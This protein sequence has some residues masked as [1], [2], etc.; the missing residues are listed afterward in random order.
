MPRCARIKSYDSVYHIMCKANAKGALFTDKA[1]KER[2]LNLIRKYQK[3]HLFKVYA[4]CLMTTHIHM[5]IDCNGSD[6]SKIMHGINQSYAQ[7]FNIRHDSNG[8]VFQDRFKS[9]IVDDDNYLVNLSAYIHNNPTDIK[10]YKNCPEKFYFSSLG[11][12][13]G[14][15]ND[16]HEILDVDFIMERFGSDV[17]SAR[18]KYYKMVLAAKDPDLV[19]E[20]EFTDEKTEYRSGRKILVRDINPEKLINFV[21][22]YTG[23]DVKLFRAKHRQDATKCRALCAFL[24]RCYC[25]FS[26]LQIC[27]VLGGLT[28]SRIASLVNIGLKVI[29]EEDQYKDIAVNFL[30]GYKVA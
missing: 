11:V 19:K 9:K 25:D 3:K 23:V 1:D 26:Y 6:I 8:H 13:L 28:L 20:V 21:M 7:Y 12:Y 14:L 2:Y 18:S 27:E 22:K 24:M 17:A 5:I 30:E 15:R 29:D 4:Y 16:V 10:G